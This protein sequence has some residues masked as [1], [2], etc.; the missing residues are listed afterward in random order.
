MT[1]VRVQYNS[2][3]NTQLK[4]RKDFAMSGYSLEFNISVSNFI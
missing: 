4:D 3:A 2:G 1:M